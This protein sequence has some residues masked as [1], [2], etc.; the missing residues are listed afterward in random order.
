MLPLTMSEAVPADDYARMTAGV[1]AAVRRISEVRAVELWGY[2]SL[3]ASRDGCGALFVTFPIEAKFADYRELALLCDA[4]LSRTAIFG[5]AC[6][7]GYDGGW[8]WHSIGTF[9]QWRRFLGLG[10][11]DVLIHPMYSRGCI[12][13]AKKLLVEQ[14][15]K[16]GIQLEL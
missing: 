10:T 15:A 13:T 6:D 5:I 16:N 14:S 4:S 9:P 8:P 11:G 2:A 7:F 1:L 3:D 12:D